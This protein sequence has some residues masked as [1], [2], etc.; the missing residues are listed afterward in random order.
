M[1]RERAWADDEPAFF[2]LTLHEIK[3]EVTIFSCQMGSLVLIP[4][5]ASRWCH[6]HYH[7]A[8]DCSI[9]IISWYLDT[10]CR[11]LQ[12]VE[13]VSEWERL[14]PIDRTPGIPGSDKKRGQNQ[15]L[16]VVMYYKPHIC[17]Q[18]ICR[19]FVEKFQICCKI[20]F[21]AIHALVCGENLTKSWLCGETRANCYRKV[22]E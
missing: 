18:Y 7:I 14:G 16:S 9:N 1:H 17:H 20:C 6:L 15:K 11:Y 13:S 3:Q 21:V 22:R 2:L 8:Y 10:F 4:I 19:E 5:L 12:K